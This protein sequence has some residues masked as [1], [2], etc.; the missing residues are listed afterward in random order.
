M[1]GTRTKYLYFSTGDGANA[2]GEACY[3]PVTSFLG[4]DPSGTTAL[5]M[6]FTSLKGDNA[7]DKVTLTITTNT[8]KIV[9]DSI[10]EVINLWKAEN[11]A[12]S[13]PGEPELLRS[14]LDNVDWRINVCDKDNNI[15]LDGNIS[16]CTITYGTCNGC[17]GSGGSKIPVRVD[18]VT[19]TTEL[20]SIDYVDGVV[21]TN[22]GTGDITVKPDRY[23]NGGI[24]LDGGKLRLDLSESAIDGVLP[25]ARGG[26]GGTGGAGVTSVGG[27]GTKNGL[28]LTGTVTST[29]NLTLGGT[30]AVNNADW[31]GTDLAIA[32][33]G[34]GAGT[35][36]DAIDAL[37]QV[38]GASTGQRLTKDSSGNAVWDD[39][40]KYSSVI[41]L[42]MTQNIPVGER[43]A[44]ALNT[45]KGSTALGTYQM[46]GA[47]DDTLTGDYVSVMALYDNGDLKWTGLDLYINQSVAGGTNVKLDFEIN[48][49][50][51]ALPL[52]RT[53][54]YTFS[55]TK[56]ATAVTFANNTEYK[57]FSYTSGFPSLGGPGFYTFSIFNSGTATTTVNANIVLRYQ[58]E[59]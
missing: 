3:F 17:G 21:A 25:T 29:G 41:P 12:W 22:T 49:H 50:A 8:H 7:Y 30:L 11:S 14:V 59:K 28:T 39:V 44:L 32:N 2:T 57:K 13:D 31:S 26:T 58:I 56:L 54:H 34:T 42:Y 43:W 33:G 53:T 27:T 46:T 19:L 55:I 1:I 52:T 10:L 20:T 48:K 6:Y 16:D 18:G 47:S 23:T 51:T 40:N 5:D 36:Q 15:F 9:M 35:A 37:T 38:S 24:K 4:F 45:G